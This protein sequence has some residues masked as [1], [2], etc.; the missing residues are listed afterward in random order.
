[1]E[2]VDLGAWAQCVVVAPASA[3]LVSRIALGLGGDLATTAL[4][5]VPAGVPRLLCPAMNP[6]MLANPAVAR[7][8]AQLREDGWRVLDPDE[9][10]LAC[11][12]S[13]PGRLPEPADIVRAVLELLRT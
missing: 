12:V 13:G 2:H 1:M 3:D 10:H 4:L 8:L 7:N 11:G 9:G 6:N 5:A